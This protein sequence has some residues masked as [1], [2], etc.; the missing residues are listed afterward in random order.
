MVDIDPVFPPQV[1]ASPPDQLQPLVLP[2]LGQAWHEPA[3]C[4]CTPHCM[5]YGASAWDTCVRIGAGTGAAGATPVVLLGQVEQR[6]GRLDRRR[7][8]RDV[9]PCTVSMTVSSTPGSV[10]CMRSPTERMPSSARS[11]ADR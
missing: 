10:G 9:G 7:I 2:Q 6:E 8:G 3:R 5:Q 4:I 1:E 11:S